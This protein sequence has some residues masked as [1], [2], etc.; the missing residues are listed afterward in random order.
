MH[1]ESPEFSS[2][3]FS[4]LCLSLLSIKHSI[5]NE[6]KQKQELSF[7]GFRI[8]V[9]VVS[10]VLRERSGT[11]G[12]DRVKAVAFILLVTLSGLHTLRSSVQCGGTQ[13]HWRT[14][15]VTRDCWPHTL[16]GEHSL[17][18]VLWSED[19]WC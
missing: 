12:C 11:V 9:V 4:C 1:A 7:T 13:C 3:L 14:W 10:V 15:T 19:A 8:S 2:F 5:Q 17:I 18:F 6:A 16:D